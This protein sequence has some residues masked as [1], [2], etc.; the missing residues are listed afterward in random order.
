MGNRGSKSRTKT[1]STYFAWNSPKKVI[2]V[3]QRI[4]ENS[5][6]GSSVI[7]QP[8]EYTI[9]D[10]DY[11][12]SNEQDSSEAKP[13]RYRQRRRNNINRKL[14]IKFYDPIGSENTLKPIETRPKLTRPLAV[15]I[16]NETKLMYLTDSVN[17]CVQ[18]FSQSLEY[19]FHFPRW[20]VRPSG[21][22]LKC[23]SG[24]TII[25]GK[26]FVSESKR[27]EIAVFTL[28]GDYIGRI[29]KTFLKDSKMSM[30]NPHGLASDSEGKL[31]VCDSGKG[32]ILI[33]SEELIPISLE[34]GKGSLI[35]PLSIQIQNEKIFILDRETKRMAIKIF[36][37]E[38]HLLNKLTD[39]IKSGLMTV[40]SENKIFLASTQDRSVTVLEENGVLVRKVWN[41]DTTTAI[42]RF[43][44]DNRVLM[45]EGS[46]TGRN[47]LVWVDA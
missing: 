24:I 40:N 41:K 22:I 46:N 7:S 29:D 27:N 19:L 38:G 35:N 16:D 17:N 45:Y 30:K 34:M 43:Y 14:E 47:E 31:Y 37:T 23:P 20:E 4:F 9:H 11:V 12:G 44:K 39:N 42:N 3:S 21:D 15:A 1:S 26:I 25:N 5:H 10:F 18:V 2:P 6:S 13:S 33:F 28:N 36:N 32:R 8:Q